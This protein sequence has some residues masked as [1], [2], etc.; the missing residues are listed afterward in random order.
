MSNTANEAEG[1][2]LPSGNTQNQTKWPV[3]GEDGI[4]KAGHH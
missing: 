3:K 2:K 4:S 1:L